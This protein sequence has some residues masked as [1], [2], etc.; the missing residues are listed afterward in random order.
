M[1]RLFALTIMALAFAS[2]VS[3][4]VAQASPV[5]AGVTFDKTRVRVVLGDRFTLET[6]VTNPRS[7]VG[8]RLIAHL[9]VASLA[10]DVYVDPEDWSASRSAYL[11]LSPGGSTSVTWHMQAVNTGTFDVYVVLLPLDAQPAGALAASPPVRLEVA[12][13]RTLNAG[14]ALPVV[15]AVPIL[16]GVVAFGTRTRLR[17]R[18]TLRSLPAESGRSRTRR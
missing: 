14:G 2:C 1:K 17:P 11:S 10:K 5:N 16:L 4:E 3:T 6:R 8:P 13:R 7:A 18:D 15:F 9:N 12:P